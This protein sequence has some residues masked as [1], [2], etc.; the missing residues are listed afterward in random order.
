MQLF[1]SSAHNKTRLGG[2]WSVTLVA[3]ACAR[4][5]GRAGAS[6]PQPSGRLK[7]K[8]RGGRIDD[9]EAGFREAVAAAERRD[10]LIREA[11]ATRAELA[12]VVAAQEWGGDGQTSVQGLER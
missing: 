4:C 5:R 12:S 1:L 11:S 7:R 2:A 6:E 3:D 10:D 9:G 8:S